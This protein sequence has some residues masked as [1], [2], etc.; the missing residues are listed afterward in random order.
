MSYDSTNY[1]VAG[2]LARIV[3]LDHLPVLK[4]GG[5]SSG[6]YCC[7]VADRP[8]LSFLSSLT[9]F[10]PRKLVVT[11]MIDRLARG[12]VP[13]TS[14]QK[15]GSLSITASIKWIGIDRSDARV[16]KLFWPLLAYF[17]HVGACHTLSLTHIT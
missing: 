10:Q 13:S 9:R 8:H 3:G 12:R 5:Q 7:Q 2:C 1:Q 15:R 6:S 11:C 16:W 4:S 17:K 14:V